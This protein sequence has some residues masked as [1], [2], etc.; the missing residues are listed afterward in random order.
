MTLK[1]IILFYVI[2]FSKFLHI[3]SNEGSDQALQPIVNYVKENLSTYQVT[4]IVK[5]MNELSNFG[6]KIVKVM[7][8]EFSSVV[9]DAET[10]R[11]DLALKTT[12]K[13][14]NR[15]SDQ[16]KLKIGIIDLRE[17]SSAHQE[18]T[19]L[20]EFFLDYSPFVRNKC[21]IFL[22][23]GRDHNL[24]PFL[25]SAWSMDFLDL[26]VIE[27]IKNTNIEPKMV[28]LNFDGEQNSEIYV[29][30]FNPFSNKYIKQILTKD[31]DILPK[32]LKDLQG[33]PLY[34]E[35]HERPPNVFFDE[36]YNGP[37]EWN[38]V[39][40]YD[41]YRTR[42]LAEALNFTAVPQIIRSQRGEKSLPLYA[43][44]LSHGSNHTPI[45]FY[46]NVYDL[47]ITNSTGIDL[48]NDMERQCR[49]TVW[50]PAPI[51]IQ[52][53][54]RQR[55]NSRIKIS[56]RFMV[57]S[58]IFFAIGLIFA[59]FTRILKKNQRIW[60]ICK[61]ISI[62]PGGSMKT[63]KQTRWSEKI[64]VLNLCIVSSAMLI[65]LSDELL[66]IIFKHQEILRFTTFDELA[67][68]GIILT[69]HKLTRNYLMGINHSGIRKVAN[70]SKVIESFDPCLTFVPNNDES[71]QSIYGC[72]VGRSIDSSPDIVDG[73][74]D[75]FST[76]VEENIL[77]QIPKMYV[78]LFSPYK[79][80]FGEIFQ[81]FL[82]SG[83]V[84]FEKSP[85]NRDYR[86][87]SEKDDIYRNR[88]TYNGRANDKDMDVPL[89]TRLLIIISIGYFLAGIT[90]MCEN[91]WKR[92]M[93]VEKI[94]V[95]NKSG[96]SLET[97]K[98]NSWMTPI[99]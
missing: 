43:H 47:Y 93:E 92:Y 25:R 42:L 15:V 36:S 62:A 86:F 50:Q 10:S 13:L 5:S 56:S 78:K 12:E 63:C 40:G 61:V 19:K 31:S 33:F 74:S 81:K 55:R 32:K 96:Y 27:W 58:G 77:L 69:M 26:T 21:I 11:N 4:L 66:H 29:H 97:R 22:I 16:S 24:E 3:R 99:I 76:V 89:C 71:N 23:S 18:L 70:Q 79:D 9:I 38:K 91:F 57:I 98:R 30:T 54:I 80:R 85:P 28:N 7:I 51:K 67:N 95:I 75:W 8:D 49:Y 41:V 65:I 68:S 48:Y 53:A 60:S 45:D 64:F 1:V 20:L 34:A 37:D 46:A 87:P 94:T 14:W 84:R 88:P 44:M 35:V 17:Q 83:L 39:V 73:K 52:L 72:L 59:M 90:L 2:L 6:I 82:E